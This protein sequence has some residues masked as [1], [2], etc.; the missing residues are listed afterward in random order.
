M[1]KCEGGVK[2]LSIFFIL[3]I[4]SRLVSLLAGY[5]ISSFSSRG[6]VGFKPRTDGYFLM[7]FFWPKVFDQSGVLVGV[8]VGDSFSGSCATTAC[9]VQTTELSC[10]PHLERYILQTPSRKWQMGGRG[11]RGWSDTWIDGQHRISARDYRNLAIG[12]VTYID[13][14]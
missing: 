6:W 4:L 3:F 9:G 8:A 13:C 2:S 5:T 11:H 14:G 12:T 7:P 1:Q 10:V